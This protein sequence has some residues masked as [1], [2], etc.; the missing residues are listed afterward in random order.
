MG[1]VGRPHGV[2]GLVHVTSYT[3]DPSALARYSP[4]V[5][6]Q[7]RVWRLVWRAEGVAEI[8][9]AAG[10]KLADRDAAAKLTNLRL[11]VSRA[12]LPQ[13]DEE[14]Y[15]LAD[16]VGL[17]ARGADGALIG[18]VRQVHDYGAGA[19]LEIFDAEGG[20][21]LIPFTKAAV[22]VVNLA[23]KEIQVLVPDEIIVEPVAEPR[24]GA[25][26]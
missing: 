1:V 19:S 24:I 6:D 10:T 4:L 23:D 9:D 7:G 20:S 22:P 2:R 25:S 26:T 8:L 13:P 17:T 11:Y 21:I 15:Y 5:D 3:D 16:L 14:E 12:Q 18:T